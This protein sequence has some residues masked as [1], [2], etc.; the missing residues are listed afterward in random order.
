MNKCG[1]LFARGEPNSPIIPLAKSGTLMQR[2]PLC[3]SL[4]LGRRFGRDRGFPTRTFEEFN[5]GVDPAWLDRMAKQARGALIEKSTQEAPDPVMKEMY[6][7]T[8]HQESSQG[9]DACEAL[10]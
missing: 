6:E 5:T 4:L 7:L 3:E 1:R 10:S 9:P 2:L 8:I